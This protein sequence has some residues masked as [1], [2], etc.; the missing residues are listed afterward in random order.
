M[1][2]IKPGEADEWRQS[3]VQADLAEATISK[4]VKH[5]RQFFKLAHRKGLVDLNPFQD[6]K[7][8]SQRNEARLMFIDRATIT[9]V[10]DAAPNAEWKLIIALA[11]FGGV[12]TPSETLALKW[13]DIDWA[14]NRMTVPSP[15]TEHQN[16]PYRVVPLFPGTA[17][18]PGSRIR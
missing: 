2:T 3:M 7:A 13:S 15:K 17:A 14:D 4:R 9:K 12:R 11:R 6:V 16:K 8:G 18:L 5:A 10:L 1:R